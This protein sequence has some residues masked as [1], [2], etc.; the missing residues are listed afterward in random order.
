MSADEAEREK[1]M[2]KLA[3]SGMGGQ[4]FD[5][6]SLKDQMEAMGGAAD[7]EGVNKVRLSEKKEG[8]AGKVQEAVGRVQ[9]AAGEVAGRAGEAVGRARE[10]VKGAFGKWM[11]GKGGADKGEL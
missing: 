4:M 10:L 8:L 11:G 9:E 1:L 6:D 7:G 3:A 5:R 2:A